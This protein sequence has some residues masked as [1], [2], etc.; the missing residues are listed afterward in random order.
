MTINIVE[1][2]SIIESLMGEIINRADKLG[3]DKK[4]LE[5]DQK[6]IL[7][8]GALD[9]ANDL[10][11]EIYNGIIQ[12]E[13]RSYSPDD[14]ELKLLAFAVIWSAWSAWIFKSKSED[15]K[16]F[17]LSREVAEADSK[18][19]KSMILNAINGGE[20]IGKGGGRSEGKNEPIEVA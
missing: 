16:C 10:A 17:P 11:K 20:N 2:I 18:Y 12:K 6:D 19:V 14:N 7:L 8:P 4:V 1:Y 9:A 5:D 13:R 15:Q 3:Y